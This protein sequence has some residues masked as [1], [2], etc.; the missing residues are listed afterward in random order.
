M[1][2]SVRQA[3]HYHVNADG[4]RGPETTPCPDLGT[5]IFEDGKVYDEHGFDIRDLRE[6]VQDLSQ[7]LG[8]ALSENERLLG[9]LAANG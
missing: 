9:E 3:T 8:E 1:F 4:T 6:Q 7:A 5:V 2:G